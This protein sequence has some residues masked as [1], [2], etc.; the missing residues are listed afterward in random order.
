MR[1]DAEFPKCREGV[2][3]PP[4]FATPEEIVDLA[5]FAEDL[6]YHA[7]WGTDF[8]SPA[9]DYGIPDGEKPDWFEPLTTIAFCAARTSRI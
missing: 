5:V 2:F 8:V 9:P 1:F 3:T 7:L 4:G 6:G